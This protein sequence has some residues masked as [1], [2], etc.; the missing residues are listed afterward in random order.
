[1]AKNSSPE[2]AA[3]KPK[4][5]RWYHQLW[6]VYKM[7]REAQ[8]SIT[9]IL[10]LIIVGGTALGFGLGV[11]FNQEVYFT[12]LALPFAL[13]G[14]MFLLARRAESTAYR[15]IEGEPGAVSAALGTIRRG[16]NIEDEPVVIDPRTQDMVFRAVGKPG[17]VLIS[18]GPPHRVKKLLENERRRTA[19][20][21]PNV[22]F[23]LLECGQEEGQIPLPKIASRVQK[24]KGKL[25]K[26]EVAEVS[27]RLRALHRNTLPIPKGVD[28]RRARPD[29]KG[30]RGR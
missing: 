1:M 12:I 27:K 14:A 5:K 19:R 2:A 29:R 13:L 17:V 15:R 28:P 10:L 11:I 3:P 16:W 23:V 25:T 4:K 21:I 8:P 26:N 18:E 24:Q 22:P 9:W 6:D 7:V 30:M 20:V